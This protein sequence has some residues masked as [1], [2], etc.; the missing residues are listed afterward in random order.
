M[1]EDRVMFRNFLKFKIKDDLLIKVIHRDDGSEQHQ[2][3]VPKEVIPFILRHLHNNMGHPDRDR[4]TSLVIIWFYW[5][6]MRRDIA[7]WIEECDRCLKFKTPDNQRAEL[8][9]MDY[10][11][12]EPCKGGIQNILVNT[13]H[14]SKFSV[15]VPTRYQISK[16]TA[17]ALFHNFIVPYGNPT[18][19]HSD[20]GANF[21][22]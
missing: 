21:F 6:R 12:L 2:V 11:T 4:T 1:T 17:D 19:L 13:D 22:K 10:L 3:V 14:F 20:Q 8:V 18:T 7:T 9:C 16:T 5:P 15:A